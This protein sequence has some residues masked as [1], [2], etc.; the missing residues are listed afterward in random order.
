MPHA[1]H[2]R[3]RT[4]HPFAG[5]RRELQEQHGFC[6]QLPSPESLYS[7]NACLAIASA[8]HCS[9]SFSK[10]TVLAQVQPER[11][12]SCA[13]RQTPADLPASHPHPQPLCLL[14]SSSSS[15]ARAWLP[16]VIPPCK[17]LPRYPKEL[18]SLAALRVSAIMIDGTVPAAPRRSAY[19]Y[20]SALALQVQS[21]AQGRHLA[22][23]GVGACTLP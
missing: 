18:P 14:I 3:P 6:G 2:Q 19:S 11:A 12:P 15:R 20:F 4:T 10:C 1:R 16:S 23:R 21:A 8:S 22:Y 5:S 17:I 9:A 7:T 13:P